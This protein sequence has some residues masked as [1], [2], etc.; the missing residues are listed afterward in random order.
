[1]AFGNGEDGDGL[2]FY[3]DGVVVES[4]TGS[5]A[6]WSGYLF[7][8]MGSPVIASL[9]PSFGTLQAGHHEF[10]VCAENTDLALRSADTT[11]RAIHAVPTGDNVLTLLEYAQNGY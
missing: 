10:E 8:W 4:Y 9:A 7:P 11:L 5:L 1:M 2:E 6:G 3:T